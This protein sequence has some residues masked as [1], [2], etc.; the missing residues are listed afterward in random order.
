MFTLA[1]LIAVPVLVV[2]TALMAGEIFGK[3]NQ[4]N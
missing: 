2:I 3:K 1:V 4:W